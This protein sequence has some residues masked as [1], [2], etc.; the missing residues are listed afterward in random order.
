MIQIQ[1]QENLITNPKE[2]LIE[3]K[4]FF[5]ALFTTRET[6]GE[7]LV[8]PPVNSN[9][10]KKLS[11][12]ENEML[13]A[14][15]TIGEVAK[16]IKN[17]PNGKTPGTDGLPVEIY[18]AFWPKIGKFIFAAIEEAIRLQKLHTSANWCTFPSA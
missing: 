7:N 1:F 4:K 16:V 10:E 6:E 8:L 3:Q 2:I 9:P 11:R 12:K 15:V 5:Q 14:P 18:K 13:E 17:M